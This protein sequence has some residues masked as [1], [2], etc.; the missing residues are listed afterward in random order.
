MDDEQ[1]PSKYQK[2]KRHLRENR[3][4]YLVG[5]G[6]FVAGGLIFREGPEI[7]QIIG[8]F[9]YKSTTTNIVTTELERRGHPGFRFQNNATGEVAG[10]LKRMAELDNVSRTFI[11]NHT[12]GDS[13][14]YTNLGEMR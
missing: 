4:V 11:R 7:K 5:T 6:A 9:N 10:S 1:E 14:L 13:P 3:K 12:K 8:S 2:I